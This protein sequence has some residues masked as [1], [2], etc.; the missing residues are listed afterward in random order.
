LFELD[1]PPGVILGS[2]PSASA[3]NVL[4]SGFVAV[5]IDQVQGSRV[6][7]ACGKPDNGVV[8]VGDMATFRIVASADLPVNFLPTLQG[9]QVFR[10]SD[11]GQ[12][13]VQASSTVQWSVGSQ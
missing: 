6:K 2:V 1:F 3:A 13:A 5:G 4:A 7:I 10:V 12:F 9:A 11:L 8:G